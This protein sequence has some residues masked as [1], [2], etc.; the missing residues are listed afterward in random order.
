MAQLSKPERLDKL[1]QTFKA[2]ED[3][4]LRLLRVESNGLNGDGMETDGDEEDE[5]VGDRPMKRVRIQ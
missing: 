4:Y 2:V 1:Q 5:E 3:D